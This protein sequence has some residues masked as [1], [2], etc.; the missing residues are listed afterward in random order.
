MRLLGALLGISVA[1]HICAA[2]QKGL[3]GKFRL[4]Y[5]T[6]KTSTTWGPTPGP[7][8]PILSYSTTTTHYSTTIEAELTGRR[9]F[10]LPAPSLSCEVRLA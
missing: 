6:L 3:R 1:E 7:L 9:V 5:V 4:W 2:R 10:W 8:Y